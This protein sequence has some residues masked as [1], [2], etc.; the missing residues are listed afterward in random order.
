MEVKVN[1]KGC[2]Y[3][4][5]GGLVF[6]MRISIKFVR[7]HKKLIKRQRFESQRREML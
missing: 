3:L 2:I 1:E 7:K 6:F 4:A 5:Y